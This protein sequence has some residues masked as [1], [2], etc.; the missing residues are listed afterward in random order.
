M[1]ENYLM[2]YGVKG[3]KWG[4]RNDPEPIN[5]KQDKEKSEY[6]NDLQKTEKRKNR[7]RVLLTAGIT[8]LTTAAATVGTMKLISHFKDKGKIKIPEADLMKEFNNAYNKGFAD[9]HA[10]HSLDN[11]DDSYYVG[12][13]PDSCDDISHYGV[14]GQK[15]GV[16][17]YQNEDGSLTPKGEQQQKND[18]RSIGQK[19][20][21]LWNGRPANP[22]T[23]TKE[24]WKA[25]K[26]KKRIARGLTAVAAVAAIIGG[27]K[28][29]DA[30]KEKK[31]TETTAKM[32]GNMEKSGD[33]DTPIALLPQPNPG[34]FSESSKAP[35]P[36]TPP[37]YDWAKNKRTT[38]DTLH[39][40]ENYRKY[41][42]ELRQQARDKKQQERLNRSVDKMMYDVKRKA[43]K[44]NNKRPNILT[45]GLI[46]S[47]IDECYDIYIGSLLNDKDFIEHYGIKGMKWGIRKDAFTSIQDAAKSAQD[48]T[49]DDSRTGKTIHKTYPDMSDDE[50]RKGISRM[51]LEQTYSK[52][53][54]DDRY[55]KSGKD[56]AREAIE[57]IGSIAGIGVAAASLITAFGKMKEVK[58]AEKSNKGTP[59]SNDQLNNIMKKGAWSTGN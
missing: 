6:E 57:M 43:D 13:S 39:I 41:K 4:I 20:S 11:Q 45:K 38:E 18:N 26:R 56:R 58:L 30:Y 33:L 22:E 37:K 12:E 7:N 15:W 17:N 35:T 40:N 16:R 10:I 55:V 36:T 8:A 19:I 25:A 24:E 52:L 42:Q 44:K 31:N 2:H 23:A 49:K 48:L 5:G 46:H 32:L 28:L 59:L 54:G 9:A 29:W 14:K 53:H 50:L 1:S 3:Q 27:K 34:H 51:Q 21:D 47:A